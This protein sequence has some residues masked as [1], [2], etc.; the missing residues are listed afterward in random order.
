ME[1]RRGR[2]EMRPETRDLRYASMESMGFLQPR[3]RL[4]RVHP[5]DSRFE[6]TT[7][8]L[9]SYQIPMSSTHRASFVYNDLVSRCQMRS[10][11]QMQSPRVSTQY[12]PFDRVCLGT[13]LRKPHNMFRCGCTFQPQEAGGL[14]VTNHENTALYD[15]A[16]VVSDIVIL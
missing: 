16:D 3:P 6:T 11:T 8:C 10:W 4:T 13:A 1:G 9:P 15:A 14:D 7:W 5:P 2:C 12:R